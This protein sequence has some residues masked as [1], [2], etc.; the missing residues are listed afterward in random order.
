MRRR[1]RAGGKSENTRRRE[2]VQ[3][4]RN[5]PMAVRRRSSS[6]AGLHKK[7]A[8][9]TRD[10]DEVHQQQAATADVLKVIS[11]STFD[12]QVVL[13]TLTKSASI[14]CAAD[15]GAITRE[16]GSGF[17]HVTNYKFPPDWIEFNK[18]IHMRPGRDSV[19]GRSLMEGKV[20]QV[21]DVLNDPEYTYHAVALKGG[22]RTFLA[23][24]MIREGRP[25]GVLVLGRKAVA[26]FSDK[27]IELVSTF[28]D[29]A[30][31]AIESVRLFNAE[32]QRTAELS[33]SLEQQTATSEVLRVISSS[34]GDL[35]P[36][37]NAMLENAVRICDAKFGSLYRYNNETFDPVALFGAPP[38]L[39]EFV[40]ERGPFQPP[41]GSNLDRLLRTRDVVRIADELAGPAP[42]ASARFAGART[43]FAVPMLKMMCDRFVHRLSSGSAALY[44]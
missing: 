40:W 23:A 10:L 9:L 32:Q 37:F 26:P 16:D 25:V 20:V 7:V 6:A 12:L 24:P 15:M 34:P 18:T 42:G 27:Q 31:I 4:R 30:A 29:Q 35:E 36:V 14:L 39:A 43:L 22:Y 5:A 3:K 1:S 28:A 41:A 38:A 8:L 13:D 19:V 33:E 17:R 21:T 44:R 11:R 2:R